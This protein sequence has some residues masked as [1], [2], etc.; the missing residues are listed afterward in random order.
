MV[1]SRLCHTSLK[2]IENIYIYINNFIILLFY[3]CS[4][5]GLVKGFEDKKSTWGRNK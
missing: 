3:F 4:E 2:K 5:S 1:R